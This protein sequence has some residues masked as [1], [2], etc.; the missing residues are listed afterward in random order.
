MTTYQIAAVVLGLAAAGLASGSPAMAQGT[1]SPAPA[2]SYSHGPD[3]M[4]GTGSPAATKLAADNRDTT[5]PNNPQTF[6]GAGGGD[7]AAG[8][9]KKTPVKTHEGEASAKQQN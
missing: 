3:P 1:G 6:F 9:A 8:A 5:R 4:A 7:G 2:Q